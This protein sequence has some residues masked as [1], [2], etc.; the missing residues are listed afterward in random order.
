MKNNSG[1]KI[2]RNKIDA[3]AGLL[4]KK[5]HA[6]KVILFGSYAYGKP[7]ECSDIDLLIIKETNDRSIDRI[8]DVKRLVRKLR[9]G[10]PFS[11]I[12]ITPTELDNRLKIGD[13]FIEEILERGVEI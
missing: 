8:V 4:Y 9:E 7:H 11:P 12:V 3:I 1:K 10:I 5:Y 2:V 6:N 13:Q